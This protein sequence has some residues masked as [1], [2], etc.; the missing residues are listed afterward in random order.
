MPRPSGFGLHRLPMEIACSGISTATT[1]LL[2]QWYNDQISSNCACAM[3]VLGEPEETETYLESSRASSSSDLEMVLAAE[4]PPI[5]WLD[6]PHVDDITV[7]KG[8]ESPC[9]R[10]GGRVGLVPDDPFIPITISQHAVRVYLAITET[11]FAYRFRGRGGRSPA[12]RAM[13]SLLCY[14][15]YYYSG[16]E[17][18]RGGDEELLTDR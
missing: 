15:Q 17:L 10:R 5:A 2:A 9:M 11:G 1:P 16:L 4:G 12:G 7:I 13:A 8:L 14:G 6:D 18:R 3:G